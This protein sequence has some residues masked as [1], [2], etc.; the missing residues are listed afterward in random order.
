MS[1]INVSAQSGCDTILWSPTKRLSIGDFKNPADTGKAMI[2]FTMTK[3]GYKVFPQEG[4]VIINTSTYF[5]PCSSWLNKSNIKNSIAHEQLHF[6]IAEYHKRLFLKRV[7]ETQ[8]SEDM[9]ATTTKAIFRDV[10]DHRRAM[11]IEYDQHTGN[12]QNEQEQNKWTAKI[13][14]LLAELEKYNGNT[15]TINL[16]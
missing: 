6:D 3:F 1:G 9:F 11:N 7:S 13:T 8:S 10:A 16:K 2:A 15:I 5:F 12:G 14:N 4:S